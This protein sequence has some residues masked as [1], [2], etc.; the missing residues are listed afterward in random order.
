MDKWADYLISAVRYTDTN[1][2]H[3]ISHLKVH[4]DNGDSI[5]NGTAW[6]KNDV[7]DAIGKGITFVTIYQNGDKWKKGEDVRVFHIS[8]RSYLRTD[9]NK[10]EEDNLGE[11]PAF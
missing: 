7:V 9:A 11:L 10:I 3:Y 5:G 8:N 1:T 6:T 4:S 2:R